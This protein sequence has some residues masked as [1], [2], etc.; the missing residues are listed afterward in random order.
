MDSPTSHN[1]SYIW[2]SIQASRAIIQRGAIWS[3][4]NGKNVRAWGDPWLPKSADERIQLPPPENLQEARVCS[5]MNPEGR[6][7]DEDLLADIF[8]QQTSK[9]IRDIQL[10]EK[11]ERGPMGMEV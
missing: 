4:G 1:P 6:R 5:L 9:M 10:S 11:E 8:D 2:R 3:I 7:W